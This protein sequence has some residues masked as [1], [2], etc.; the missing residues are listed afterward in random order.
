MAYKQRPYKVT[1]GGTGAITAAGARTNL[2]VPLNTNTMLLDGTQSMTAALNAGGFKVTNGATPTVNT[3]LA[4][5]AYVDSSSGG[6][7]PF[8]LMGA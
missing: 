5:K 3:D 7:D 8:M 1:D 6:F 4:T 2:A